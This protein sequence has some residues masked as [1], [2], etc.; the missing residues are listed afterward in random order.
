MRDLQDD[1]DMRVFL[2]GVSFHN[3][4]FLVHVFGRVDR[5]IVSHVKSRPVR[6]SAVQS[7][8]PPFRSRRGPIG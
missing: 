2:C 6:A 3:Y 5:H 8:P 7:C 1:G 4:S